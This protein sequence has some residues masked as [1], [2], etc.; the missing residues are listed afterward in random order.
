MADIQEFFRTEISAPEMAA[1]LRQA[2]HGI[3]LCQFRMEEDSPFTEDEYFYLMLLAEQL[4][5]LAERA[6]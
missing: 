1:Y 5:P 6:V 3:A 4:H 2:A